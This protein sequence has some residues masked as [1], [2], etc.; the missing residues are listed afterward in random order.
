LEFD[1]FFERYVF[2]FVG[3]EEAD[4]LLVV[5]LVEGYVY[6]LSSILPLCLF[7]FF[8]AHLLQFFPAKNE[9]L[10]G[11]LRADLAAGWISLTKNYYFA[12]LWWNMNVVAVFVGR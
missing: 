3:V 9:L 8:I 2:R 5:V 10:F 6:G 1:L 12:G 7:T 11:L 4:A